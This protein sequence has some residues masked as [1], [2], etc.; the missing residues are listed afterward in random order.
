MG[1]YIQVAVLISLVIAV[2]CANVVCL[3]LWTASS[4]WTHNAFYVPLGLLVYSFR[5][6]L[7]PFTTLLQLLI[8]YGHYMKSMFSKLKIT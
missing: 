2:S 1:K 3:T 7:K 6:A 4:T 8:A 5:T